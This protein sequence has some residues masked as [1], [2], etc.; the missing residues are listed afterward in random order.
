LWLTALLLI[1][2]LFFIFACISLNSFR[3]RIYTGADDI[4]SKN[5]TVAKAG[6]NPRP[7]QGC[8]AS[9]EEKK[10]MCK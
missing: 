7:I 2:L 5:C 10:I 3:F 4:T 9:E 8:R 6:G 1:P